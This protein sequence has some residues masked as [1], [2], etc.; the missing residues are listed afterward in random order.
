[1]A[2]LENIFGLGGKVAIVTGASRG[3][4]EGCARILARAGAKVLLTDILEPEGKKVA[5]GIRASGGEAVFAKQDVS[6]EEDWEGTVAKAVKTFGGFDVLVNNAGMEIVKP[7][8][9]TSLSDWRHLHAVN[10]DGVFL[11]TRQAT[12]ASD[13]FGYGSQLAPIQTMSVKSLAGAIRDEILRSVSSSGL[14]PR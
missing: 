10:L 5:E 8:V 9:Q 7:I 14:L 3:I 11:G 2:G 1:M 4:G 6:R 13:G 12:P